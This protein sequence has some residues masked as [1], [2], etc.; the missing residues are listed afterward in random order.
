MP[1]KSRKRR[2]VVVDDF[3]G[4]HQGI[5]AEAAGSRFAVVDQNGDRSVVGSWRVRLG[6]AGT[7]ISLL[8]STVSAVAFV[9]VHGGNKLIACL[10]DG[11][12]RGFDTPTEAW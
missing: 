7:D 4:I 8:P 11:T 9:D 12:I 3:G 2:T 5:Q 1:K 6:L 10:S